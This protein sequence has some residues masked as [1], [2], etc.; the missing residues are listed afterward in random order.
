[1]VILLC[2]AVVLVLFVPRSAIC[3]IETYCHRLI[4]GRWRYVVVDFAVLDQLGEVGR[5]LSRPATVFNGQRFKV[6]GVDDNSD[7]IERHVVV[8][9]A[10]ISKSYQVG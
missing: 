5:C 4:E 3:R 6:L 7:R 10:M 1:M 9:R 2:H 8:V